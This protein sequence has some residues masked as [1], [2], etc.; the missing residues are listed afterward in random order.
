MPE[1]TSGQIAVLERLQA[2]GFRVE[3]FPLYERHIGI[4]KGNCAA[5]LS[6]TAEGRFEVFRDPVFLVEGR[7]GVKLVRGQKSYFVWKKQ[8][9]EVTSD[10]AAELENFGLELRAALKAALDVD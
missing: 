3:A 1:L 8:A 7:L 5:L 9:V 2:I 10:R 6:P 4:R